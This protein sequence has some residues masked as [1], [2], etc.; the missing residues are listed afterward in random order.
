ML[1]TRL[2]AVEQTFERQSNRHNTEGAST[3][4]R[5]ST[6]LL[7]LRN[8]ITQLRSLKVELERLRS[9][10]AQ[11]RA[12]LEAER[13]AAQ[14]EWLAWLS[15]VRTNWIKPA[16]VFYLLQALTND[17]TSVRLEATRGL[18]N[19]GL[20]KIF[21]TNL[22]PQV[23][24]ELRSAAKAAIPGLVMSLKDPDTLVRANAAITLG[25]LREEPDTVVPALVACLDDAED[26]VAAGA[27]KALGRLQADAK[28]AVSALLRAARST[29]PR[30]REMAIEALTQ[31][32]PNAV[33]NAGLQ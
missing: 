1:A 18:R 19:I 16:D 20:Q 29:S 30:R 21:D 22:T 3:P 31:I 33:S 6:E 5:Q 27:A 17:A 4:E 24:L 10:N 2:Q 26:R 28:S 15:G 32:D 25:F 7:R 13:S 23:E 9:E 8:E 12:S 14:A 11:L